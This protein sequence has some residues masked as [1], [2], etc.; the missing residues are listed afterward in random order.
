M[1]DLFAVNVILPDR[2]GLA[3]SGPTGLRVAPCWS[4]VTTS[5]STASSNWSGLLIVLASR[6]PANA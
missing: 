3:I 4:S 6:H 5:G 1:D 2:S